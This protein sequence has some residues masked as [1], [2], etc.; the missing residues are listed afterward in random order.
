MPVIREYSPQTR[1]IGANN[2][3]AYSGD[4]FGAAQ[5][6]AM[7]GA[8]QVI[9]NV[10]ETVAKR[11][12]QQNASDVTVKLTKANADLAI[13]LQKTIRTA[14][15]G[16]TKAFE[17]YQKRME[18]TIG[19]IGEEAN[20]ASARGFYTEASARIKGQLTKTS[21][22][23]QA[24]LA[25][26]KAVQDYSQTQ[27][28]LTAAVMADPS[29]VGLQRELHK[30]NL[31]NLVASGQL[32]R[33]KAIQLE[34][35]G[36][37]ALSKAAMRG[38][39]DLNPAYA[40]E[41]LKSGEFDSTLGA[42]GKAQMLGEIDQAVRAQEVEQ[43]RRIRQQER[44]TKIQQQKTQNHFL[45]AMTEGKLSSKDILG[46]NLEAFGSGSKEQ[47]LN[48]MK[49]ANSP[50]EKL[51]TDATTMIALFDRIQ[52]PDGDPNKLMDENELNGYFGRGLSI[53]DLNRLRD[54][55][56]GTQTDA[57]KMEGEMKRQMMEIARGKLTKSNPLTG[58]KDPIGD[59][60][61]AKFQINF[62]NEYK[63]QRTAGKSA[64]SLLNPDSPEY[65][66]KNLM[67]YVRTPQ[68]IMR[69]LAPKRAKPS[70]GGLAVTT[71]TPQANATPGVY[72]APPPAK[73][74]P[75]ME[76]ES[77]AAYLKRIKGGQ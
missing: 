28:N 48:M 60:Q 22:D 69:D 19:K 3:P 61:M 12:D 58:F 8:G 15:P 25:G 30:Q 21:I 10:A 59:E 65:L 77:A 29:G 34:T 31:A 75:R 9:S 36:E 50:D 27:N 49:M 40:K 74:N 33:E 55:I 38:W 5:A 41:K 53:T 1:S 63:A 68:Q 67:S 39:I 23:G 6:R 11:L 73:P 24:E 16:D 66:G 54:E 17:E 18:D 52:L 2:G 14:E 47:F 35:Q 20:T 62:M 72:R 32:P 46:S 26:I 44:N 76:G 4:Q 42:D 13:D 70:D 56:Q 37:T 7:E 43:E 45:T 71:S 57:G 64:Q 51:K